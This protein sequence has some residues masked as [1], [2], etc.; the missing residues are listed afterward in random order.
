MKVIWTS[1]NSF[2]LQPEDLREKK[3]FNNLMDS[4]YIKDEKYKYHLF[5]SR[6]SWGIDKDGFVSNINMIISKKLK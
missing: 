5:L 3:I 2:A 4:G 1:D 6:G